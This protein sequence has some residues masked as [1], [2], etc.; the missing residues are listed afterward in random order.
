MKFWREEFC[1][2]MDGDA[3]EKQYLYNIK[4]SYGKVGQMVNY[5]AYG[6]M[7][8]IM[9]NVGPGENHGCP[10]KHFDTSVLK[11]KLTE[12]GLSGDGLRGCRII[13]KR[14]IYVLLS[15]VQEI[16]DLSKKGHYQMACTK[17]YEW[18]HSQLPSSIINHPNQYFQDSVGVNKEDVGKT[19]KM[20]DSALAAQEDS[21][22][23]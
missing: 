17:Y 8:I 15:G 11:Q 12:Y 18:T 4:H 22:N 3:F 16:L 1:K 2:K 7:K 5:S 20:I 14:N 21:I 9:S 10:F 19:K 23:N 6:C 13:L